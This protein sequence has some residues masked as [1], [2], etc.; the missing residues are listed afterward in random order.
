MDE[1]TVEA[2]RR[3]LWG[4]RRYAWLVVLA[5]IGPVA[6]AVALSPRLVQDE[7]YTARALVIASDLTIQA[8][9]LARLA[10][11]I[12]NGGEVAENAVQRSGLPFDPRTLIPHHAQ[13][14]PLEDNVLLQVVGRA[15]DPELASRTANGVAEALIDELNEPGPGVGTFEIQAAARP[16]AEPDPRPSPALVFA[17]AIVGGALLGAGTVGLIVAIRRPVLNARE[18]SDSA[19]VGA[20][21][22]LALPTRG[23]QLDPLRV[24]GLSALL[25]RVYPAG[26]GTQAFIAPRRGDRTRTRVS[27][28]VTRGLARRGP[29]AYVPGAGERSEVEDLRDDPRI[30]VS[31]SLAGGLLDERWP[32][33]IDGPSAAGIDMP[34]FIPPDAGVV[35]VVGE[36]TPEGAVRQAAE[37]FLPG[38]L[39]GVIYIERLRWWRARRLRASRKPSRRPPEQQ[40]GE[41]DGSRGAEEHA[42]EG[43]ASPSRSSEVDRPAPSRAETAYHRSQ[44]REERGGP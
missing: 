34:Q 39:T 31:E 3:L 10:E 2:P 11:A 44:G 8:E 29:V 18:A 42:G 21:G 20:I 15:G 14:E 17:I 22:A 36:G 27:K 28:L 43:G 32:V 4:A 12:F 40:E 19:G 33:V 24:H 16:P 23:A 5:V 6:L 38:E 41:R 25:K 35:L 37:L 26:T 9:Q 7:T 1:A 13:L 30:V